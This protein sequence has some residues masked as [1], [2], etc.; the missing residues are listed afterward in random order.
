MGLEGQTIITTSQAKIAVINNKMSWI[1]RLVIEES[2][3]ETRLYQ[4]LNIIITII[5]L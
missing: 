2:H 4:I 5:M 3:Q 1:L